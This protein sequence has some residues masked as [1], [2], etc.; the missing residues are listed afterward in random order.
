MMD[1]SSGDYRWR[2]SGRPLTLLCLYAAGEWECVRITLMVELVLASSSPRRK[3]LVALLGLS[4]S[5]RP[6]PVDETP[7]LAEQPLDY[8][9]R[10]TQMKAD[11][12]ASQPGVMG[13]AP[14]SAEPAPES[15]E[16]VIAADTIVVDVSDI[17]GKPADK[18]AAIDMLRRLRGRSHVVCTALVVYNL[19]TRQQECDL[20]I[21]HV[22]MRNYSDAEIERYVAS[23]DPLD[24]AGAYAVQHKGFHPVE[25]FTGCYASVMG[26]PLCHVVRTLKK[27]GAQ[28]KADVP[29]AC[30]ACLEYHC[31]IHEAVL[32][33]EN[34]G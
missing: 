4:Y 24:K 10:V 21:S 13:P 27:F 2:R 28:P 23:G 22:P 1:L 15:A 26:F 25:S 18:Q 17:L 6:I 20:C 7:H 32:R 16:L 29:A 30:Q 3:Q 5:V 31:P 8:V 12:Y 34:I 9:R 14:E 11:A 33:G 19:L